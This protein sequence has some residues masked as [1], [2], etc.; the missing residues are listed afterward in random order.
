MGEK[1]WAY[2]FALVSFSVLLRYTRLAGNKKRKMKRNGKIPPWPGNEDLLQWMTPVQG[3]NLVALN[4]V[5]GLLGY[6]FHFQ[7]RNDGARSSG[8]IVDPDKPG[9][10]NKNRMQ[11]SSS[12]RKIK[13]SPSRIRSTFGWLLRSAPTKDET[14]NMAVQNLIILAGARKGVG[15]CREEPHLHDPQTQLCSTGGLRR[16]LKGY[17]RNGK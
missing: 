7:Q 2:C 6:W 3:V 5:L 12:P 17:I 11:L 10:T 1:S 4:L 16:C 13:S 9:K 14:M 15:A 8:L